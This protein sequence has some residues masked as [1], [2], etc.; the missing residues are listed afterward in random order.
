MGKGRSCEDSVIRFGVSLERSL[1][2]K[3][4]RLVKKHGFPNRSQAIRFLIRDTL[5]DEA[6]VIKGRASMLISLADRLIAL[7]GMK[8]GKLVISGT[9]E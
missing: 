2:S 4:D 9:D 1:L 3:L 7:K 8:H 6:I 5:I